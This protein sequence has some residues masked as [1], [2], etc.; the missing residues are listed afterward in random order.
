MVELINNKLSLT[1]IAI[2]LLTLSSA[3]GRQVSLRN[4]P[5][6]NQDGVNTS[7]IASININQCIGCHA[8]IAKECPPG[9]KLNPNQVCK[10]SW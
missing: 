8:P 5:A 10:P 1:I 7:E 9:Q 4:A 6:F 3:T 2:L